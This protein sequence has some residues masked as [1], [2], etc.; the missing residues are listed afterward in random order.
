MN[1]SFT[2]KTKIVRE[3]LNEGVF[4]TKLSND[5][6]KFVEDYM[7]EHNPLI[8]QLKLTSLWVQPNET[9]KHNNFYFNGELNNK[10]QHHSLLAIGQCRKSPI[11]GEVDRTRNAMR[12]AVAKDILD[13]KKFLLN[14]AKQNTCDICGVSFDNMAREEIHMHHTGE[15]QFRHIAEEFLSTDYVLVVADK[16][17]F[18]GTWELV[19]NEAKQAW[20]DF[21]NKTARLEMVCATWNLTESKK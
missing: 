16:T 18:G 20:I 13:I 17:D 12:T 1:D 14:E 19:D 6:I 11:K 2:F 7:L 3:I 15:K 9:F 21:H 10:K 8:T 5:K 4:N